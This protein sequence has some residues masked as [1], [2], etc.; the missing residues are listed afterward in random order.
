MS[1]VFG[2]DGCP[3]GWLCL[4]K[5][6]S[7]GT[8]ETRILANIGDLLTLSPQ[9]VVALVDVPIGLTDA[10]PRQCDLEA[11]KHLRKPRSNSVFPAPIRATL[12]ATSYEEACRIGEQAD[13]RRLSRQLWGILPKV[14]EVDALLRSNPSFQ[15]WIRE[16]H[17]EVSFWAWNGFVA[18]VHG[19]KSAP[20]KAEREAL[21][22]REYGDTYAAARSSL[23]RSQYANDDLLDAFAALWSAERLAAGNALLLPASPPIDACGL[24]MEMVA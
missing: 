15:Q 22:R 5:D 16:V 13:G 8:V 1:T 6:L 18:M 24:R 19:K 2:I 17:P 7:R 23:P 12:V 20:G 9:P 14:V 11:R 3:Q 10:G 4:R 21:V